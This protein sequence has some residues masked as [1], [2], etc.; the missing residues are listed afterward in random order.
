MRL[1][2]RPP[3]PPLLTPGVAVFLGCGR[4]TPISAFVSMSPSSPG[5][6]LIRTP[7]MGFRACL[8][9]PRCSPHFKIFHLITAETLFP[10]KLVLPGSRD[11]AFGGHH[12]AYYAIPHCHPKHPS[13]IPLCKGHFQ[14]AKPVPL[15]TAGQASSRKP[16]GLYPGP[17]ALESPPAQRLKALSN[18]VCGSAGS[19]MAASSGQ[20]MAPPAFLLYEAHTPP[21]G[22]RAALHTRVLGTRN[23]G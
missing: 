23:L 19:W 2:G 14:M 10:S 16:S 13:S 21:P 11:M 22:F 5:G 1:E 4:V 17:E 15:G 20:G 9:N 3:C 18:H 7:V 8:N 12:L 6:S